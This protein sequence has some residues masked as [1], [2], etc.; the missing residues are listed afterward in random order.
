MAEVY[1]PVKLIVDNLVLTGA[2][3]DLANDNAVSKS[4]VDSK[5]SSAVNALVNS[6]PG[7]LDTLNE[8]ALALNNDAN[9]AS[10]LTSAIGAES[11]A[12]SLADA[13]L[14]TQINTLSAA[15]GGSGGTS[16]QSQINDEIVARMIDIQSERDRASLAESTEATA[17][18]VADALLQNSLNA[19][20]SARESAD[21]ISSDRIDILSM[22]LENETTFRSEEDALLGGR[23]DAE[24]IARQNDVTNLVSSKFDKVGGSIA[25]DVK[26][27]DSYLNFGDNWRV[28]ASADGSKIVFQHKKLDNVWRT[29]IPFICS[30]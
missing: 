27:V 15:T 3:V 21:A 12:R 17:R 22:S 4:Y 16:L 7:A 14:Q 9:L 20:Q 19:E 2:E 28:K 8:I 11:T 30:V 13:G 6:A 18:S 5:V 29:A 25:G 24:V 26:L 23:I 10:T 1:E